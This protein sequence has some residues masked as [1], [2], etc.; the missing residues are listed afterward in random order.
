MNQR[1]PRGGFN[2]ARPW[3]FPAGHPDVIHCRRHARV[4]VHV[5]VE[6]SLFRSDGSLFDR[7]TGVI[8]DLSFSG[9]RLGDVVLS[10]GR[11][12]AM[13]FG[14]RFRP[15]LESTGGPDIAGR[16]LR[17]FSPGRPAFGIEFLAPTSGVEERLRQIP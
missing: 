9:A 6:L 12:L 11:L 16:I 14:V 1:P 5:P 17:T 7:G 15:A 3:R 2:L 8:R 4:G 10:Q 13:Q